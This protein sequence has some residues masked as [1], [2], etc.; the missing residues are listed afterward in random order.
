MT[1]D[2]WCKMM[3]LF[4]NP[5]K[6]CYHVFQN[7]IRHLADCTKHRE[8]Q[9]MHFRAILRVYA[10]YLSFCSYEQASVGRWGI[11]HALQYGTTTTSV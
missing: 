1:A 11:G 9:S 8:A 2:T 5:K 10:L 6:W 4:F 7:F 3:V